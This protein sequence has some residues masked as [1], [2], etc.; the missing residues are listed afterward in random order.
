VDDEAAEGSAGALWSE[1]TWATF[2][3][4]SD[5]VEGSIAINLATVVE[6]LTSRT[7][8]A[9]VF[10]FVRETL[11]SKEWAPLSVDTVTGAHVGSDASI[12][13]HCKNSPF[14]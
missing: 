4:C 8:V 13:N 10:R 1:R 2:F 5:V 3:A 6:E 12:A 14:P 9:I 7:D 11:G